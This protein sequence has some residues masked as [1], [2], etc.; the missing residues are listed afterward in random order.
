MAR[1]KPG[2][3]AKSYQKGPV[4]YK[5]TANDRAKVRTMAT[6]GFDQPTICTRLGITD[7]T[8]RQHFRHELDT[9]HLQLIQNTRVQIINTAKKGDTQ[10]QIYL[11]RVLGWN[12]R[13]MAPA[14]NVNIGVSLA[15]MDEAAMRA[16]LA[17]ILMAP[18]T[19]AGRR[20]RLTIDAEPGD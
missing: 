17:E 1:N 12:D 4:E 13:P 15:N 2:K 18:D 11:S 9:A 8:L 10:A 5:P 19:P 16:E 20:R 3:S 7:K 14:V 6:V